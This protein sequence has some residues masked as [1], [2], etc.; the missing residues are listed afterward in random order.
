ML[1]AVWD[2]AYRPY[3]LAFPIWSLLGYYIHHFELRQEE[4]VGVFLV[5]DVFRLWC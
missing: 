2:I 4:V 3:M 5:S 1:V